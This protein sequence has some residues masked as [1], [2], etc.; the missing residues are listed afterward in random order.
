MSIS[1]EGITLVEE[2]RQSRQ[3]MG[4]RTP[5]TRKAFFPRMRITTSPLSEIEN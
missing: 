5:I 3:T 2:K 4:M 1:A